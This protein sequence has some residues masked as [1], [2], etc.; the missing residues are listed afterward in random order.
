LRATAWSL[1]YNL[2]RFR[3]RE[4][5][6]IIIIESCKHHRSQQQLHGIFFVRWLNDRMKSA[7][8]SLP[9]SLLMCV[10]IICYRIRER[11]GPTSAHSSCHAT[12]ESITELQSL[13][14]SGGK[15]K[16]VEPDLSLWIHLH[17]VITAQSVLLLLLKR[18]NPPYLRAL[19]WHGRWLNCLHTHS[20]MKR[21]PPSCQK[22]H[23]LLAFSSQQQQQQ[24]TFL[25]CTLF[26]TVHPPSQKKVA[27]QQ[28][29]QPAVMCVLSCVGFPHTQ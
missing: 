13:H 12:K 8:H 25:P 10:C 15:D 24:L 11:V 1:V 20:V 29:Q 21:H 28:Q 9:N 7:S 22:K 14:T 16:S 6:I 18:A 26:C 23:S 4:N 5:L 17:R 27:A 3:S 19:R 2:S